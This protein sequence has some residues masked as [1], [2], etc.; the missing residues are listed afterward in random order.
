MIFKR[1]VKYLIPVMELEGSPA[2]DLEG[3]KI[4]CNRIH[5]TK[6][7]FP[8]GLPQVLKGIAAQGVVRDVDRT[9]R[10]FKNLLVRKNFS[11]AHTILYVLC[12]NMMQR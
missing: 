11:K 1:A 8:S 7:K 5:L 6:D 2:A 10:L 3:L 12:S 4:L 9:P